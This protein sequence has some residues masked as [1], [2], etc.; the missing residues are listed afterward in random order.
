MQLA[1]GGPL[2]PCPIG[3]RRVKIDVSVTRVWLVYQ[4]VPAKTSP[5][6]QCVGNLGSNFRE[7]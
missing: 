1:G 3:S 6:T 4:T 5:V 2:W 7:V